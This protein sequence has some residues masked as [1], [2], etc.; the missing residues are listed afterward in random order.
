MA[1]IELRKR[2]GLSKEAAR[3]KAAEIAERLQAKLDLEWRWSG[4]SI[5]FEATRGK[6]KGAKGSLDVGDGEIA[7]SVDLPFLLR[8]LKGIVAAKIQAK[9]DEL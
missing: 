2:H 9:L 8:P 1:T 4:D 5:L 6:A 3:K 7:V